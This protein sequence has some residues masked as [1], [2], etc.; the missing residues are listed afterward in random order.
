[1]RVY[2]MPGAAMICATCQQEVR[3]DGTVPHAR[4][5]EQSGEAIGFG[6]IRII[7]FAEYDCE[8]VRNPAP[9]SSALR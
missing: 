4:G 7:S 3:E 9:A 5:C 1:M 8:T 2:Y 6:R